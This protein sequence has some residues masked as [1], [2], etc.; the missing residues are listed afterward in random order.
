LAL[1][2]GSDSNRHLSD[3][4]IQGIIERN[5][6]IGI[7][8]VNSFLKYGWKNGDPRQEVTL[9]HIIAQIDHIC[10]IAGN[11]NHVGIGT[12]FDGGFGLQSVPQ[13]IDSIADIKKIAPRLIEKGYSTQEVTNILGENWLSLLRLTLPDKI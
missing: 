7:V 10:Q 12:D 11:A 13:D 6:I 3:R 4:A 5:G 8:P 9:D 2:K 1:L